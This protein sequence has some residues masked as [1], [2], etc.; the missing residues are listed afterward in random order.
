MQIVKLFLC[1]YIRRIT[2]YVNRILIFGKRYDFSNTFFPGQYHYEPVVSGRNSAMRGSS[3]LESIKQL[4]EARLS[5][6]IRI[7]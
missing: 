3:L 1:D 2:H 5:F 4:P 6:L 7:T